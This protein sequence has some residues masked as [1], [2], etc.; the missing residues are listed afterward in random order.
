MPDTRAILKSQYHASL[1]T[2]KQAIERCPD[3]LWSR[4]D[5]HA[6]AFWHIAYHTLF[7][8]HLYLMKE[9]KGFEAWEHH[10]EHYQ[11]F[12]GPQWQP[13][14]PVKTGEH[15]TKQQVLEYWSLCDGMVDAAVDAMDLD[16]ESCGFWWYEMP[17]LEH[18]LVNLRHIQHGAA[19]LGDRLRPVTGEGVDWVGK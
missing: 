8:T 4:Q 5:D 14:E 11:R 18:Q 10:R 15:Y 17:K 16:A 7:F 13:H 1:Q 9:E 6:N 3:E 19:Q 2:L 12:D